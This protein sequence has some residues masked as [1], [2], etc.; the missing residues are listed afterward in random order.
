MRPGSA[1][2]TERSRRPAEAPARRSAKR[3]TPDYPS[4]WP[5]CIHSFGCR[6]SSAK[7]PAMTDDSRPLSWNGCRLGYS[8]YACNVSCR[9]GGCAQ[10]LGIC[11]LP[12]TSFT[13]SGRFRVPQ[14]VLRTGRLVWREGVPA[15]SR[16]SIMVT[17]RFAA[18]GQIM[19]VLRTSLCIA[20][21]FSLAGCGPSVFTCNDQVGLQPVHLGDAACG[22]A[23]PSGVASR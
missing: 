23:V 21:V 18:A 9:I 11:E 8:R 20:A 14:P 1:A 22:R 6:R 15:K 3:G 19:T 4:R 12:A 17:R 16:M 5:A 13:S 10:L 2:V 7:Q